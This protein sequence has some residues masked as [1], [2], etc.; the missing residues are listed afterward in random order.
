[1]ASE[2]GPAQGGR[3]LEWSAWGYQCLLVKTQVARQ[4]L[5]YKKEKFMNTQ[6]SIL[7][8]PSDLDERISEGM[9]MSA[10]QFVSS[11]LLRICDPD[12]SSYGSDF[13]N[14]CVVCRDEVPPVHCAH[15]RP[16][17]RRQSR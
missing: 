1:M 10:P 4:L 8:N 17:D 12:P 9:A 16:A 3:V 15:I 11:T 14:L 2:Q 13:S 5:N 6:V 7:L